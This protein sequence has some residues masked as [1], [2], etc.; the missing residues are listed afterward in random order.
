MSEFVDTNTWIAQYC[1][2]YF[3]I[4][5]SIISDSVIYEA[6]FEF[7]NGEL[8]TEDY[9]DSFNEAKEALDE[10]IIRNLGETKVRLTFKE[11]L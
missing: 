11:S 9:F 4:V 3:S 10:M 1:G 5:R 8:E 6:V 7:P 2:Y